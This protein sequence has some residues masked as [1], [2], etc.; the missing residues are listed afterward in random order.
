MN[1]NLMNQ[2]KVVRENSHRLPKEYYRG[3][4]LVAFTV[5]MVD[6]TPFWIN[7]EKF[8]TIANFLNE[9]FE[10]YQVRPLVYCLMPD[11]LHV[12]AQGISEESDLWRTIVRFKQ[13]SSFWLHQNF[14]KSCWQK[15]FHDRI[16]RNNSELTQKINYILANPVRAG[17]VQQ[18]NE[19]PFIG[20]EDIT[21]YEVETAYEPLSI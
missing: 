18:W 16:I 17:L 9:S 8:S 12:V 6:R 7:E 19:Y 15:D 10:L 11:H 1:H 2:K 14:S 3:K 4:I 13:R 21:G 5:C 20:P